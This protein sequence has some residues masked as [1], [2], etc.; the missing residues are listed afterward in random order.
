M[1]QTTSENI[2]DLILKFPSSELVN[3]N[4]EYFGTHLKTRSISLIVI[5][6]SYN[7]WWGQMKLPACN[8]DTEVFTELWVQYGVQW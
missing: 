3:S 8:V 5:T 1:N 7:K 6:V 4:M 2:D